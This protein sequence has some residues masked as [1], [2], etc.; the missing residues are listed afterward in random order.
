MK[1]PRI[2]LQ[3]EKSFQCGAC[4]VA[5]VLN[6]FGEEPPSINE[7]Y[8]TIRNEYTYSGNRDN[9]L[10]TS[11]VQSYFLRRDWIAIDAN[12]RGPYEYADD[13]DSKTYAADLTFNNQKVATWR[14]IKRMLQDGYLC[15]MAFNTNY[16]TGHFAIVY[17]AFVRKN[18]HWL[19]IACS[20]QG[21]MEVQ[22]LDFLKKG[23]IQDFLFVKPDNLELR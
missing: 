17:D 12:L 15:C 14:N 1:K 7:L 18:L 11:A 23:A 4:V 2:Y 20:Q 6:Y 3:G 5:S 22:A 21:Y 13:S 10:I 19:R 9:G 16:N 8:T